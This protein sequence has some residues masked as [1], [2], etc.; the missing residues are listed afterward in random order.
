MNAKACE[1]W[2]KTWNPELHTTD[3]ALKRIKSAKSAKLTPIKI[4]E[5][6]CYG[7]FQ[8]S[9]GKYET[10]LGHCPCGD[11]HRSK[12]PCKH[13]YRLAIELGIL[14]IEAQHNPDA[15][16]IPKNERASLDDTMD[17]VEQLSE[18]AQRKLLRI[19][20]NIRSTTPIY[21]NALSAEIEELIN[22]GIVSESTSQKREIKFGSKRQISQFLEKEHID[23]DK[24]T[25]KAELEK[26]CM[27]YAPEKAKE[28]FGEI[29]GV[30]IHKK[31][32]PQNIHYYLHRKYD[33]ESFYDEN[34]KVLKFTQTPLL[35]TDLPEDNITEQLIKRG[36]YTRK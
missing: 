29:I 7:Y 24:N 6:D 21:K 20:S 27:K 11:F 17:I 35:E 33:K 36:Y 23:H 1:I 30:T 16:L 3:Y 32:S 4:D 12:L 9:H 5:T 19:A 2:E 18:N 13:I 22:S 26:L 31:Y 28:E 25:E 8:G 10:W 15:V 14:D 34:E